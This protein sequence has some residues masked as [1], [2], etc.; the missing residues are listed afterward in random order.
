MEAAIRW[1]RLVLAAVVV[2]VAAPA[3]ADFE[4]GWE[5]AERG[6]YATAL[7][8]L[9]PL[10]EQGVAKAQTALGLLYHIGRG[11]PQDSIEAVRWFRMAAEQGNAPGQTGLGGMYFYGRGVPQD[12][13]LAQMWVNLAAAQGNE[14]ARM[15]RDLLAEMMTPAQLAEAQR[16]A[17]EWKPKQ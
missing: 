10:A 17:R 13:V 9:R 4:A 1:A 3:W 5:A 7:K 12:D 2:L 8:E 16:L 15:I 11:V 14:L 6:D